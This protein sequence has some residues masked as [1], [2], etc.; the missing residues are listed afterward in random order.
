ML[1]P[2]CPQ[3]DGPWHDQGQVIKLTNDVCMQNYGVSEEVQISAVILKWS[4]HLNFKV[5]KR[6]YWHPEYY[7]GLALYNGTNPYKRGRIIYRLGDF[8]HLY[9]IFPCTNFSNGG[10]DP[11]RG[12]S[13][14]YK[15]PGAPH[16]GK[17]LVHAD[18][19]QVDWD[20]NGQ[21]WSLRKHFWNCDLISL[22]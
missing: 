17:A 16:I 7:G 10:I 6:N 9:D 11:V 5:T 8:S 18:S 1:N 21:R 14:T 19:G 22:L 12:Y 15:K 13:F 2:S 3:Q 20:L 4:I